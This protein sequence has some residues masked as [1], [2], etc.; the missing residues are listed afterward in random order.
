MASAPVFSSAPPFLPRNE[1]RSP[2]AQAVA[3]AVTVI[4]AIRVD[5]QFSLTVGGAAALVL[6]PLWFGTAVRNRWVRLIAV[7]AVTATA[8]GVLLTMINAANHTQVAFDL[9]ARAV[10]IL[11]LAAV[12][13]FLV[14]A[15]HVTS[16][17]KTSVAFA[18][19]LAISIP[20]HVSDDP[21][22]WRFTLSVPLG[23]F[24]LALCSLTDRL[25]LTLGVIAGL[26]VIGLLND[27]R[28]NS[29]FLLLTGVVLIWQRLSVV[30][31]KRTRGWGGVLSIA[32]AGGLIA[33]LLQS[34]IL[35]GYFGEV[36]QARTAEQIQRGG[37]VVVGG[38]PELAAS[39][40]L[41]ARY[42]F[43]LGSGIKASYDDIQAAKS[44][45]AG[46]GYDPNNGYVERFMFGSGIEVH[47]VIGD[48][49]IWYGLAGVAV[50]L[51]VL[52]L[53]VSAIKR[54]YVAG[55][56]TPLLVY[57]AARAFWDLAFSPFDSALRLWPL[58]ISIAIA[59]ATYSFSHQRADLDVIAP[60]RG[61]RSQAVM[62]P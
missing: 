23:V 17:A 53:L 41:I 35:E 19:G 14:W 12:I 36:T 40:A 7:L 5:L 8:S 9:A 33:M 16:L 48:Y 56:L 42:P 46:I 60:T 21:N 45:M 54:G 32:A 20:L 15:H 61:V 24:V 27:S 37:S 30:G 50:V 26:A 38:R 57:L 11:Q 28:S 44:A 22:L 39:L 62:S 43:G 25:M 49:W 3:L 4:I 34:A 52:I 18:L 10:S 47:S 2:V 55:A 58:T 31:S 13:G 6:L 59:Y 1:V 51:A 29:A